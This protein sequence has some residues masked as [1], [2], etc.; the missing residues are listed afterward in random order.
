[1]SKSYDNTIEIFAPDKQL[2]KSVMRIVTDSTPLEDP[3]DP[4]TCNV[5]HLLELFCDEKELADVAGR[6]RA[7]GTGYGDFKKLLLERVHDTFDEARARRRELE[8]DLGYVEEVFR[9][10][11]ARARALAGPV[12]D[13]VHAACGLR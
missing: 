13:A 7:G 12:L 8:Q 9:T 10:G 4:S 1:M 2:K 5:Y 6:Y 3:K 11:A